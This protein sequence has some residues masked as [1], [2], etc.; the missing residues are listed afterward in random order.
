M[1]TLNTHTEAK[2]FTPKQC[3]CGRCKCGALEGE[4]HKGGPGACEFELC[5]FCGGQLETCDCIYDKNGIKPETKLTVEHY[6][7]FDA[8]VHKVRV[9][10]IDWPIVCARCGAVNRVTMDVVYAGVKV[11]GGKVSEKEWKRYIEI[12]HRRCAICRP[13]YARIKRLVDRGWKKRPKAPTAL[14]CL[15]QIE[16]GKILEGTGSAARFN[17]LAKKAGETCRIF[18][19]EDADE[20]GTPAG[21][22]SGAVDDARPARVERQ[23]QASVQVLRGK[24]INNE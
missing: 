22:D 13:C 17:K 19:T 9:P 15:M 5:P 20:L 21:E 12:G 7:K 10:Y 11:V 3:R 24:G 16:A 8:K 23:R 2:D 6:V 4:V 1:Q 18:E 14:T